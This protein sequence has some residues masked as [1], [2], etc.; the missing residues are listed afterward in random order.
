M[1]R[2]LAKTVKKYKITPDDIDWYLPHFSSH[3]FKD[4]FYQGMKEAGFEIPYE[5]WFTNLYSKG[6]TGSAAIF[7]ILEE[8]FK[9]GKLKTGEKLL[10]FIPESGRFS[11]CFMLLTVV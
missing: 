1:H 6:N 8:I 9:S 7:I 11:H 3:Y 2:L 5:K 10:C 4:K